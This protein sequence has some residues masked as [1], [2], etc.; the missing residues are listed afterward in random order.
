MYAPPARILG[1]SAF[2]HAVYLWVSY[3][4]FNKR[5]L[6]VFL[7]SLPTGEARCARCNTRT[8]YL[9]II[10]TNVYELFCWMCFSCRILNVFLWMIL[11]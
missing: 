1:K 7:N 10:W 11:T 3:D 4:S 6:L 2:F 9:C 8:E 5:R